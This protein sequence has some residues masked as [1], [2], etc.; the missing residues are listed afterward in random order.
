[1]TREEQYRLLEA[2]RIEHPYRFVFHL[3]SDKLEADNEK[4][5][6]EL[7]ASLKEADLA[8][9]LEKIKL[10]GFTATDLRTAL[11]KKGAR[12]ATPRKS[13][14]RKTTA[15]KSTPRKKAA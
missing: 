15:R 6:K 8:D 5:R 10:H 7:L 12:K 11:K 13:T 2:Y 9:V 4:K 14:A 3:A 1:L